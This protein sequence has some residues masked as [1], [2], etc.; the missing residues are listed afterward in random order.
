MTA[1]RTAFRPIATL[2]AFVLVAAS[3]ASPAEAACAGGLPVAA[4]ASGG[5]NGRATLE[6]APLRRDTLDA[7]SAAR[8]EPACTNTSD[9][10]SAPGMSAVALARYV[11]GASPASAPSTP[12]ARQVVDAFRTLLAMSRP[13]G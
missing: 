6:S 1:K 4:M 3:Q 8:A 5:F 7:R 12:P 11:P 10:A 13:K 9:V 2:I